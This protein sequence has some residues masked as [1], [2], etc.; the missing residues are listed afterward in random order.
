M[1]TLFPRAEELV[2]QEFLPRS[3]ELMNRA[4]KHRRGIYM[5]LPDRILS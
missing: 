5:L 1:S 4:P 3:E 2:N